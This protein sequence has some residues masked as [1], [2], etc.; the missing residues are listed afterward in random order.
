[1]K[2]LMLCQNSCHHVYCDSL[3]KRKKLRPRETNKVYKYIIVK[4]GELNYVNV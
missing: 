2:R 1:M 3:P 4:H